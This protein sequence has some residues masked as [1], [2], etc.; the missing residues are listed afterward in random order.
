MVVPTHKVSAA[1][2]KQ[3]AK[4]PTSEAVERQPKVPRMPKPSMAESM[5]SAPRQSSRSATLKNRQLVEEQLKEYEQ[6][7]VRPFQ[8]SSFFNLL[9]ILLC[10][11]GLI[12]AVAKAR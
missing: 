6:R 4:A 5:A 9:L 2:K 7:R 10:A 12:G 3:V 1:P 8:L 11:A